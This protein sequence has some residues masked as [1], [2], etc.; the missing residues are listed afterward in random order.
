VHD[1]WV[2][3]YGWAIVILTILINT[4]LMPLKFSSMKSMKKMSVLQ[5][6]VKKIQDKYKGMS[7]RDP[8]RQGQNEELMK[9]YQKH[10]VNPLGGCMPMA[11]QIP[12]FFAFYQVLRVA[13]EL[14]GAE[15]LWV[16]DLSQPETLPIR[17]LPVTMVAS[18]FA[19]QK[20]TPT[21]AANPSQQRVMMFMPLMM[22][23]IFYKVS[24]G[25]V[26]YWLTS[27]LV[28]VGQQ[29]LINK[30]GGDAPKPPAEETPKQPAT[31]KRKGRKK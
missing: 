18:Q 31:A 22:G 17:I 21:T 29:L 20:M 11:L 9:L 7:M 14:R 10:N 3:N 4:L 13:I 8:R 19:M 1:N 5:P 27:N 15:W 16:T 12:F 24:S 26:L 6:E 2:H 23:F 28:G 30:F 25:L